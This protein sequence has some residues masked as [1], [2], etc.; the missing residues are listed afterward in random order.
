MHHVRKNKFD[1]FLKFKEF[2]E[3]NEET[4]LNCDKSLF[5][6][7]LAALKIT[8]RECF[9]LPT[10]NNVWI[11]N[12]YSIAITSENEVLSALEEEQFIELSTDGDLKSKLDQIVLEDF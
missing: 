12:L 4:L 8:F 11:R 3:E 10:V 5:L 6:Q 2:L 9:P 7:H 1:S